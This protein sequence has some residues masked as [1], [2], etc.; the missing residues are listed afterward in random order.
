LGAPQAG[1]ILGRKAL[2]ERA[3]KDPM[4]R[5][6]RVDKLTLAALEA[7]LPAYD[8]PARALR[9]IPALAMLAA[10]DATLERRARALAEA[11]RAADPGLVV[12]VERGT[13]EVGGGALPLA[14]LAGWV[15]TAEWKEHEAQEIDRRARAAD[16]PVIGYIRAGKFRM[17]VRTL[18]DDEIAEVAQAF[19]NRG[20]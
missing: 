15:V 16:P 20:T 9:E 2:V 14:R 5:A 1:L 4:A 8:E 12:G 7:T 11:V 19:R 18:G 3:R 6:L 10:D 17:D 13:G